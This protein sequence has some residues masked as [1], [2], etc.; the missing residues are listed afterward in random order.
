MEKKILLWLDDYRDPNDKKIDWMVFS[1][2]GRAVEIVWVK[3]YDEFVEWIINNK[4][5]DGIAFDHDLDDAHYVPSEY[6]EDYEKSKEYQELQTYVE[7]TGYDAAKWL[8]DY[9]MDNELDLPKCSSHSANPVG[10]D[11]IEKLLISFLKHQNK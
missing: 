3:T 6:W 7:K 9:C 8:T 5:P 10:R 11:N 4:L 1:P 2:I